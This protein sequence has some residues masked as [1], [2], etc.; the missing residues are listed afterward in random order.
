MLADVFHCAEV[1]AVVDGCGCSFKL[2]QEL[3]LLLFAVRSSAS[4]MF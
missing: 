3:S 4:R 2:I 1:A